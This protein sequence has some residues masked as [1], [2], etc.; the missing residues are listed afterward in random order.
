MA[1]V[2]SGGDDIAL[3][4]KTSVLWGV[5]V[6]GMTSIELAKA[7]GGRVSRAS[8]WK[9]LE[10]AVEYGTA[11]RKAEPGRGRGIVRYWKT[12]EA[13]EPVKAYEA[14]TMKPLRSM[15]SGNRII[16][17]RAGGIEM[18]VSWHGKPYETVGDRVKS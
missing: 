17:M 9:F 3:R 1:A 4:H 11:V 12:D 7:T 13:P 18:P 14:G 15:F 8:A 6:S 2:K 5:F 16:P 10:R